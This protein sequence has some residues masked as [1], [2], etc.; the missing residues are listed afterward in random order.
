MLSGAKNAKKGTDTLTIIGWFSEKKLASVHS[1]IIHL[2]Y[3]CKDGFGQ[4]AISAKNRGSSGFRHFDRS[5]SF[6]CGIRL[7]VVPKLAF[8]KKV[9]RA[10]YS[11]RN[12]IHQNQMD[13]FSKRAISVCKHMFPF[14]SRGNADR[15][16][17]LKSNGFI[18]I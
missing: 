8:A 18:T 4:R 12:S 5:L 11:D 1:D 9:H 6:S 16:C 10:A 15:S 3:L 14:L 13:V 17:T 7:R 2:I